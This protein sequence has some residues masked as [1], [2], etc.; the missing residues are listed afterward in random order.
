MKGGCAAY[1]F[2]IVLG[3]ADPPGRL[4]ELSLFNPQGLNSPGRRMPFNLPLPPGC[5]S[6]AVRS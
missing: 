2:S 5:G 1:I 4:R 6:L 3:E